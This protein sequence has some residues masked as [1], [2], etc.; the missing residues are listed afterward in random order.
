MEA[1]ED[2]VI[3]GAGLAGL[4]TALGLHRKGIKCLILEA[5]PELRASGFGFTMWTNAW[6]AMDAL[7]IGDKLREHHVLG[8]R[9]TILS[10]SGKTLSDDRI[11][12]V[13]GKSGFLEFRCV[14][15]D[16]LLKTLKD[17]LPTGTI[18]YSSKIVSIEKDGN[19]KLLHL[20]DGSII[21]AK[22][23]IGCDGVNSVVAKYLGLKKLS[24]SGR[25]A[26][27]GLTEYESEHCFKPGFLQ[28]IGGGHRFGIIPWS[29][30]S[31]YWFLTWIASEENKNVDESIEKMKD[32][33]IRN[34]KNA[35]VSEE[36]IQLIKQSEMGNVVSTP[37]K[38]RSPLS[39]LF[40]KITEDNVCVAGDALHATTPEIGQGGCMALEDSVVLARC[41]SEVLLG[42]RK[43]G[44]G[45]YERIEGALKK[46]AKERRWRTIKLIA[47]SYIVGFIQ[48]SADPFM[49][50]IRERLLAPVIANI[51]I[52]FPIYD[53]GQL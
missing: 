49:S 16:L 32:Y 36:T 30:K 7:G 27:R 33:V 53:C 13:Q 18:R 10:T 52:N 37:L 1:I 17:E 2:I 50:F 6:R 24:Y 28:I 19:L 5:S 9:L 43:G 4:A 8:E 42:S 11:S 51:Y 15:R 44:D 34:L 20:F 38:Y 46:F 45:E 26:T 40:A 12:G 41:L 31:V 14:K 35:N 25:M 21:K 22:V 3:V 47:L 39:L 23:L 29:E 48:Q